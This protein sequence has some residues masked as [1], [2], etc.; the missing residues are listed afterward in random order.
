MTTQRL[1][2][3]EP[4]DSSIPTAAA[5]L[6][7]TFRVLDVV[8]SGWIVVLSFTTTAPPSTPQQGD[9]YLVPAGAT[10]AWL[11]HQNHLAI[12]TVEGWIF[13]SPRY[14]WIAVVADQN[15]PYGRIL[16]YAGTEWAPWI[17]PASQVSFDPDPDYFSA[18]D[19]QT[20]MQDQIGRMLDAEAELIDHETRITALEAGGGGGG[21][22]GNVTP[23]T[24]PIASN[25][26]NDEFEG[27]T[28]DTAGTR[29]AGATAWTW[30][31]QGTATATLVN[32][33]LVLHAAANASDDFKIIEQAAPSGNFKRRAKLTIRGERS[34][35]PQGGLILYRTTGPKSLVFASTYETGYKRKVQRFNGLNTFSA[36]VYAPTDDS[37]RFGPVS[38]FAYFEI[39]HSG[40]DYIFRLS[41]TGVEGSFVTVAT[42]AQATHLGGVADTIG[43]YVSSSNGSN[44]ADMIC[45]WFRDP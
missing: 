24:H 32:G 21:G 33:S 12:F 14:G 6:R 4:P 8:A 15:V 37:D 1:L 19:L 31:N 36:N 17:L 22:S 38:C 43:L 39:E 35:F 18:R 2:L 10:G 26:S 30:R 29:F 27:A 34:N 3:A 25:A 45:D 40:T 11:G 44:S 5:A 7:E 20:V 28:L 9:A 13:R 23:D 16:Q 41:A 42:E